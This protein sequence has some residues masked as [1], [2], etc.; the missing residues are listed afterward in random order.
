[1]NSAKSWRLED[2]SGREA[3]CEQLG[4]EADALGWGHGEVARG[5]FRVGLLEG[6]LADRPS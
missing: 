6:R 4:D 1:M 3:G 5:V 2:P